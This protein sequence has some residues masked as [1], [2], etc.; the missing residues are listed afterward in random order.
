[1]P[2]TAAIAGAPDGDASG[3]VNYFRSGRAGKPPAEGAAAGS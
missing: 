3:R 1:M 2:Q